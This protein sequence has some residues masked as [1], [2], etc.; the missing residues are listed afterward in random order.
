[1]RSAKIGWSFGLAACLCWGIAH[2]DKTDIEKEEKLQKALTLSEKRLPLNELLAKIRQQT[3]VSLTVAQDL[4]DEKVTLFVRERPAGE[5]LQKVADLYGAAWEKGEKGF[6]LRMTNVMRAMEREQLALEERIEREALLETLKHIAQQSRQPFEQYLQERLDADK[7]YW[8]LHSQ[9]RRLQQEQPE[10]WGKQLI[11]TSKQIQALL[12]KGAGNFSETLLHYLVGGIISQL[13]EAQWQAFWRGEPQIASTKHH[14]AFQ[15]I[16]VEAL[17]W[18]RRLKEAEKEQRK[19]LPAEFFGGDL[20]EYHEPE[21]SGV[22]TDSKMIVLSLT[23]E[24]ESGQCSL[25]M[26]VEENN[27]SLGITSGLSG[28]FS[29]DTSQLNETAL[30][31]HWT[32]RAATYDQL[33]KALKEWAKNSKYELIEQ[34]QD[35]DD[36]LEQLF[37][38]ANINIIADSFRSHHF[39]SHSAQKPEISLTQFWNQISDEYLMIKHQNYWQLRQREIPERL[40][41]PLINKVKEGKAINLDDYSDLCVKLSHKQAAELESNREKYE[42]DTSPFYYQRVLR[43]W[44]SLNNQQKSAARKALP[45][46]QLTPAQKQ[47]V[48]HILARSIAQGESMG[49]LLAL[50]EENPEKQLAISLSDLQNDAK[51]GAYRSD[52]LI[53]YGKSLQEVQEMLDSHSSNQPIVLKPIQ[54]RSWL[55]AMKLVVRN[56]PAAE[57]EDWSGV[58]FVISFTH[59]EKKKDQEKPEK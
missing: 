17:I 5:I 7:Q 6:T 54:T 21:D 53:S 39:F 59:P 31:K 41:R 44:G 37:A 52:T 40:L 47:K 55:F 27:G 28:S 16:P 56:D 45:Y 36:W 57:A 14:P 51:F 10:G 25:S 30:M 46:A 32:E 24:P 43:L 3:Q 38:Q 50:I 19:H 49:L 22:L 34:S 15:T 4:V 9:M 1:M 48:V 26:F 29:Q 20:N 11:E 18:Q 42:F 33:M 13:S 58:N 8:E 2:A 35:L 23:Y 12:K